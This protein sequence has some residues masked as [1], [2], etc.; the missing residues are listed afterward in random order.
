MLKKFYSAQGLLPHITYLSK[1]GISFWSTF[2]DK[3]NPTNFSNAPTW[4]NL[5]TLPDPPRERWP[6]WRW[7]R[8]ATLWWAS[9]GSALGCE[10]SCRHNHWSVGQKLMVTGIDRLKG[11]RKV[12]V[13]CW[14][15][16]PR[17]RLPGEGRWNGDLVNYCNWSVTMHM[18]TSE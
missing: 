18:C 1:S 9:G 15:E 11:M 16:A 6:D 14:F 5:A 17:G 13:W 7:G 12:L 8:N 10:V 2:Q 3:I 4:R